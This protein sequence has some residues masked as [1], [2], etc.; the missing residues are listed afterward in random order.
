MLLYAWKALEER[1]EERVAVSDLV[2]AKSIMFVIV[3]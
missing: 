2:D 3:V 1:R